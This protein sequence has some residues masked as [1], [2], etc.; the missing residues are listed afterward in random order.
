MLV[1]VLQEMKHSSEMLKVN[2]EEEELCSEDKDSSDDNV[3]SATHSFCVFC[4]SSTEYQMIRK[5]QTDDGPAKVMVTLKA[6]FL[7]NVLGK[8]FSMLRKVIQITCIGIVY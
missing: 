1:F 4:C 2:L 5:L 7:S 3:G 6:T 8:R